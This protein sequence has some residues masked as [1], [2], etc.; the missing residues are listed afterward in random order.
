MVKKKVKKNVQAKK[1]RATKNVKAAKKSKR[2]TPKQTKPII[3]DVLS[4]QVKNLE[5]GLQQ[6]I[7]QIDV[8]TSD[9]LD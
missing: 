4:E 5:L 3:W 2:K 1:S 6:A 9:F 7:K 8:K